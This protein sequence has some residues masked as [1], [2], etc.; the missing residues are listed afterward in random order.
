MI[1]TELTDL[2]RESR[3]LLSED[4]ELGMMNDTP[5]PYGGRPL[6]SDIPDD[7]AEY[8]RQANGGI[9]GRV[10]LFDAKVV[11]DSQFYADTMDEA[12]VQLGREKWFCIGKVNDDP[13]F[14]DRRSG[15]IWG[16][17]DTGVIWWQ[18]ETFEMFSRDLDGFLRH[19]AFGAGYA[20]LT[21]ATSDDT[22]LEVLARLR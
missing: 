22:W 11:V 12:P 20:E 15:N 9:F 14:I 18:S 5:A 2:L 4:F 21:G 7:Y 19:Y 1:S 3:A 10:V 8:L 6:P 17:P 16:F 13:I